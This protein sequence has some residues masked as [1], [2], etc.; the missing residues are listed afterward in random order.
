LRKTERK[1]TIVAAEQEDVDELQTK[2]AEKVPADAGHPPGVHVLGLH[3]RLQH[4][5]ELDGD[6]K[7]QLH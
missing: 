4:A 2:D 3:T 7:R 1:L 6:G 5:L